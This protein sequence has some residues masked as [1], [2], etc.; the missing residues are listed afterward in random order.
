MQRTVV[1]SMVVAMGCTTPQPLVPSDGGAG[2]AGTEDAGGED[3]AELDAPPPGDAA[4][5]EDG[6]AGEPD[7]GAFVN[8]CSMFPGATVASAVTG[9]DFV[10][11]VT[12]GDAG[13]GH[14]RYSLVFTTPPSPATGNGSAESASPSVV[15]RAGRVNISTSACDFAGLDAIASTANA[16]ASMAFTVGAPSTFAAELEPGRTYALNVEIDDVPPTVLCG[17]SGPCNWLIEL[18]WPD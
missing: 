6:A 7:G 16:V 2:E 17:A 14:A 9:T 1:L 15:S 3:A 13:D 4:V 12:L 8:R 11:A 5:P 10:T 18:R